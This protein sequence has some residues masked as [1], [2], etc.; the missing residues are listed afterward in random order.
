M[1]NTFDLEE[2]LEEKNREI[3]K[4]EDD[5]KS[6]QTEIKRLHNVCRELQS[7]TPRVVVIIED[8]I[9]MNVKSTDPNTCVEII[10]ID[11]D[12][13][14]RARSKSLYEKVYSDDGL[15]DCEYTIEPDLDE[16]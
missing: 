11:S 14:S 9:V 7:N 12:Y 4:L 6:C 2:E 3:K 8:G 16:E 10:D 5:L 13:V 1:I 15:Y